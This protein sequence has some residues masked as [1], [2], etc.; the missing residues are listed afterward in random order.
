MTLPDQILDYLASRKTGV[1]EAEI[2]AN[3]PR[4]N[5]ARLDDLLV[6]LLIEG[7]ILA[8]YKPGT[9][10]AERYSVPRKARK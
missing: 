6:D 10:T 9:V 1:T 8:T 5:A 3:F 2:A 4:T 7:D